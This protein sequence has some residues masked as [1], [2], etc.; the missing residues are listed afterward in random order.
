[1]HGALRR[2]WGRAC[3]ARHCRT[4]SGE[5]GRWPAALLPGETQIVRPIANAVLKTVPEFAANFYEKPQHSG[6]ALHCHA[7]F[8][9][10]QAF[11]IA[12][13]SG[14]IARRAAV[15]HKLVRRADALHDGLQQ[16]RVAL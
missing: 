1:M 3:G 16:C 8:R 4:P 15:G 13:I 14:E 12:V 10:W 9:A 2:K 11:A 5:A 7:G 6:A